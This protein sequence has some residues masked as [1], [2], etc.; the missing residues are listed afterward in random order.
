MTTREQVFAALFALG[1][2]V[3]WTDPNTGEM[4]TFQYAS[5]RVATFDV[6]PSQ[7]AICQS[8]HDEMIS[9]ATNMPSKVTLKASWVIYHQAGN[10]RSVIPASTTNSIMDAVQSALKPVGFA[11]Q[12]LGGLAHH[13]WIDGKVFRANGD[14]DGQALIVV[15]ISILL[16]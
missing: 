15:P 8:E 16:P 3:T 5:R 13:A 1:S 10:D 12:T 4:V 9:Q 11:K 2:A 7:P 14:I 6:I